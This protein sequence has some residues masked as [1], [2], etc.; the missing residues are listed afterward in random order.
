MRPDPSGLLYADITNPQSFN[1]YAYAVN[2]PLSFVDP[3]GLWHCVWN[4]V[5]DDKGWAF[6]VIW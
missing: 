6:W 5:T 3:R 4:S 1:L 2:N